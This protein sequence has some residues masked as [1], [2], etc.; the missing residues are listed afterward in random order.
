MAGCSS[1]QTGVNYNGMS[2]T[3]T[4]A[5]PVAHLNGE[6]WGL[7]FLPLFPLLTGDTST[8]GSIAVLQ[9]TVNV[10]GVVDMTTKKAKDMGA[11][12]VLDITSDRTSFPILFPLIWY[13]SVQ[14]SGN[15][16]K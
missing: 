13:K 8:P 10:G 3:T 12:S 4:S 16:V 7:Y 1:V 5:K 9:N 6:A 15:A 14:V 11:A 2:P